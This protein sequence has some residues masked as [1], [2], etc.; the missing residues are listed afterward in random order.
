MKSIR[1]IIFKRQAKFNKAQLPNEIDA[2]NVS[3]KKESVPTISGIYSKKCQRTVPN[4]CGK[5]SLCSL[6]GQD[7]PNIFKNEC[8]KLQKGDI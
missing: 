2:K 5:P 8:Y 6:D 3:I 1:E 4:C 7:C